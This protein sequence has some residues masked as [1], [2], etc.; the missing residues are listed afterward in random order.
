MNPPTNDEPALKGALIQI[1]PLTWAVHN[2][3]PTQVGRRTPRSVGIGRPLRPI[4]AGAPCA[5]FAQPS[6]GILRV[7]MGG[8]FE[9][10]QGE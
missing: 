6:G 3:V 7:L 4:G 8:L 1:Q 9:G 5:P 10:H 2:L